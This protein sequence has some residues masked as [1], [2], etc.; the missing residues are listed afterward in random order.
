MVVQDLTN[1]AFIRLIRR[2]LNDTYDMMGGAWDWPTLSVVSPMRHKTMKM[3]RCEAVR[4][5]IWNHP[6]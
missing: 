1:K 5:G 4:R 3:L 2:F 6:S